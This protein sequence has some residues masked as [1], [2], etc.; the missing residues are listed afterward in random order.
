M[1][2]YSS[3]SFTAGEEDAAAW[4]G[5]EG[6]L[7][8]ILPSGPSAAG[9]TTASQ[10]G[11]SDAELIQLIQHAIRQQAQRQPQPFY[12]LAA[13]EPLTPDPAPLPRVGRPAVR[14]R[15]ARIVSPGQLSLIPY[16]ANEALLWTRRVGEFQGALR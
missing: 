2:L 12:S 16:G 14:R 11:P 15:R 10:P 13:A 3:S 1:Q 5:A 9:T 6:A 8:G 4:G 7:S